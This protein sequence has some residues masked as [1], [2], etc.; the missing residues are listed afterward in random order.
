MHTDDRTP[1]FTREND[2]MALTRY[3]I[4]ERLDAG[5]P[6][7][8]PTGSIEQHG[9]HLPVGTDTYAVR[10]I[11][12][13]V[14]ARL[15]ALMVPFGPLGVTPFH[16]KMAGAVHLSSETFVALFRD[17]CE[18][19]IR[20][21]ADEIVIVNWHEGST[22]SIETAA[23]RLQEEHTDVRFVISQASYTAQELYE[24]YHDLTHGG[25]LEVLPVLAEHPELVHLDRATDA[26]D[27][28]H[29]SMMDELRRNRQAYPIIPDVRIMYESGWYGD[30]SEVTEKMAAEFVENVAATCAD[31]IAETLDVLE[32]TDYAV[33][34]NGSTAS[35][36]SEQ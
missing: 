29:A 28:E 34:E 36:E 35:G 8:V 25:P 15:D 12:R 17:V 24:D 33:G 32:E 27:K 18:S 21:G 23:G 19:L 9:P 7:V 1:E 10:T 20:H 2:F 22:P 26:A 30:V 16:A 5:A 14:A 13:R 3:E 11:A 31:D 6:V 4:E